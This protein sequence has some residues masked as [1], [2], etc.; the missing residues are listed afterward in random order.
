MKCVQVFFKLHQLI[1]EHRDEAMGDV[2]KAKEGTELACSAPTLIFGEAMM[3][4]SVGFDAVLYRGLIGVF[5]GI[6]P[7]IFQKHMFTLPRA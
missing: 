7:F 3:N 6:V 2:L 1:E 4:T 5:A